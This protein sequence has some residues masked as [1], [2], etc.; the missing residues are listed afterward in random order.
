MSVFT[1]KTDEEL[2]QYRDAARLLRDSEILPGVMKWGA[3][4][5]ASLIVSINNELHFRE[6]V[7]KD[8]ATTARDAEVDAIAGGA[9]GEA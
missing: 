9:G 2:K 4:S 8:A 3:A 6:V 1:G 5:I 7:R